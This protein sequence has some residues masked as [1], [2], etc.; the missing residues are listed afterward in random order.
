MKSKSRYAALDVEVGY[1]Q[2]MGFLAALFLTYMTEEDAF[3][4][5][6]AVLN[7]PEAPFRYMYCPG[8][9]AVKKFLSVFGDLGRFYLPKLWG[10][11]EG[12]NVH[13]SMFLT[14]WIMTVFSRNF[15]FEFVTRVWD[16]FLYEGMKILYR[17]CL[18]LLKCIEEEALQTD[19]EQIM[20]LIRTIPQVIDVERALDAAWSIPLHRSK[21]D[22]F[23]IE[24]DKST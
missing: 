4:C 20:N 21:I 13:Q 9:E 22:E 18:G 15:S 16:M 11:F 19:F 1:C 24:Y 7:R 14:E 17:V 8:M 5:L 12:E 2:G 3:Y 6:V 10:H 23:N